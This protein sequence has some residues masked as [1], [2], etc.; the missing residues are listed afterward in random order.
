MMCINESFDGHDRYR[1]VSQQRELCGCVECVVLLS[2]RS[3]SEEVDWK[4]RMKFLPNM[5]TELAVLIG[6]LDE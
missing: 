1:R 3:I 5:F 2:F 6:M 4:T